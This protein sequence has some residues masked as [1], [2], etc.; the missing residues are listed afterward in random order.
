[1]QENELTNRAA[2]RAKEDLRHGMHIQKWRIL[3]WS[4]LWFMK[5]T[6]C[7]RLRIHPPFKFN[8]WDEEEVL[9]KWLH[10]N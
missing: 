7:A 9:C 5:H 1:M 4:A 8:A 2:A 10:V 6:V 3:F